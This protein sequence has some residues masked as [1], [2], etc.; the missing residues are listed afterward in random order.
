MPFSK[1]SKKQNGSISLIRS[2]I[3]EKEE[4]LGRNKEK[5]L[6]RTIDA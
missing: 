1:Y 3:L 6:K 2:L 4:I 5:P